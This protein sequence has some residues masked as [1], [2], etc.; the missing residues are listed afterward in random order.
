M[1]RYSEFITVIEIK[2]YKSKGK[3]YGGQNKKNMFNRSIRLIFVFLDEEWGEATLKEILAYIFL[4]DDER[5]Q[6]LVSINN[7]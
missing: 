4:S 2:K 5:H 6:S 7:T 1:K 3:R